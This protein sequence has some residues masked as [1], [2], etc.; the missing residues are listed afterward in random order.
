MKLNGIETLEICFVV[1][2]TGSMGSFITDAKKNVKDI[3]KAVKHDGIELRVS[4]VKYRDHCDSYVTKKLSFTTDMDKINKFINGFSAGGG[5][6]WPEAV[7]DALQDCVENEF[8]DNSTR[9]AILVADAPPHVCK[10]EDD[11]NYKC[12]CG[13]SFFD[14]TGKIEAKAMPVYSISIDRNTETTRTF[15]AIS[16]Y[17]GGECFESGSRA[18][19][20]IKGIVD[21]Q[22]AKIKQAKAI[23]DYIGDNNI[24]SYLDADGVSKAVKDIGIDKNE[25][26]NA[27]GR[28]VTAGVLTIM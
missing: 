3:L 28:L 17:T 9:M 13:K 23:A 21:K 6:D 1:D 16:K 22:V 15:K 27:Y 12:K 4:I 19:A 26:I 2:V 5:G 25:F 24:T 20:T 7:F 11:G 18:T 14:T 10:E 8:T